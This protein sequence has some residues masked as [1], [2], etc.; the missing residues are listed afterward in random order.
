[1]AQIAVS[2]DALKQ[3]LHK[4]VKLMLEFYIGGITAPVPPMHEEIWEEFLSMLETVNDPERIAGIL[5]K[6]LA[7][8]RGH[9]KTTLIK[10]ACLLLLR[11]SK[12]SFLA[13][14]S[15]TA[16]IAMNAIR[17]LKDFFLSENDKELFGESKVLRSSEQDNEFVML[18]CT[19]TGKKQIILKAYG[20]GTQLRG[21]N[22]KNMRPD[23]LIFDDIESIETAKTEGQQVA[24]DK[25]A[26][27]TAMKAMAQ[28]GICI[29]IGNMIAKTTLLARL[30]KEKEWNPTVLGCIVKNPNTGE[31]EPLWGGYFTLENLLAE[32]SA[33]VRMGQKDLW[34]AEMMNLTSE[35]AFGIDLSGIFTPPIPNPDM[36]KAGFIALDPAF[37]IEK[38]HDF[39]AIAIHIQL[40][41][42]HE[43]S[44]LGSPPILAQILTFKGDTEAVFDKMLEMSYYW[45]LTTWCIESVAAQQLLLPLFKMY[46]KNRGIPTEFFC[47]LPVVSQKSK[48]SRILA[49]RSSVASG[50]YLLAEGTDDVKNRLADYSPLTPPTNDDDMDAAAFGTIC[51]AL[52]GDMIQMNGV[53]RDIMST[54][55]GADG[56]YLPYETP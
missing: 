33:F 55:H 53:Q 10:L 42:E 52:H 50:S 38:R 49:F 39:T 1:M 32:Y 43:L 17:D 19:A 16:S 22:R 6:L 54:I 37:G 12:L 3:M 27:G 30:S 46:M 47:L 34:L 14:T 9:A 31:Y 18:I 26:L 5:K 11:Y 24:I 2:R 28:N 41:P 48:G 36:V 35:A 13:Y 8:P 45:G 44:S 15:N 4:D 7:I 40:R 23:I 29:F 21:S 20:Q 56:R 25:W 51:W